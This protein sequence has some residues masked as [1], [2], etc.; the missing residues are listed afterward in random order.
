MLKAKRFSVGAGLPAMQTPRCIRYTQLMPSQASQ[1]LQ[2]TVPAL[3]FDLAFNTQ[4][5]F[6]AAVRAEP[7]SAITQ[8]TDMPPIYHPRN[9]S[10]TCTSPFSSSAP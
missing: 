6:Q 5:G 3:A 2:R 10:Q 7:I 9:R 8:I 4:A 1:L